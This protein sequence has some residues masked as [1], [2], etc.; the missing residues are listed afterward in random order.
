MRSWEINKILK[1]SQLNKYFWLE[2]LDAETLKVGGQ[3]LIILMVEHKRIDWWEKDTEYLKKVMNDFLARYNRISQREYRNCTL[4]KVQVAEK[5][6]PFCIILF[7]SRSDTLWYIKS[8]KG[9]KLVKKMSGNEEKMKILHYLIQTKELS[10]R[11]LQQKLCITQKNARLLYRYLSEVWIFE[12]SEYNN[13]SKKYN[14][15][16]LKN[17]N[18]EIIKEYFS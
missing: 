4:T 1:L 9:L 10:V 13:M 15:E 2:N 6:Y 14:L 17:L 12:I 7:Q 18:N 8:K 16:N 11:K 3:L 5:V